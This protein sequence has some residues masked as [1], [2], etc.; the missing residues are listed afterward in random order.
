[1]LYYSIRLFSPDALLE[2]IPYI[3]LGSSG[4]M[5]ASCALFSSTAGTVVH[6][7]DKKCQ[8]GVCKNLFEYFIDEEMCNGCTL[9][10][11]KC[12]QEAISGIRKKL[13]TIDP[14][15]CIKC[16]IC[17]SLCKRKAVRVR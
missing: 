8:A 17:Y 13:H 16:G 7:Y 1:M 10:M 15:K 4:I 12:P 5:I 14:E 6:I 9:C 3:I 11:I 2:R